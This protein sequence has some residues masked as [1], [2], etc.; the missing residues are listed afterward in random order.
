MSFRSWQKI[1][2]KDIVMKIAIN[3]IFFIFYFFANLMVKF[4]F[5]KKIK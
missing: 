5:Y 2:T 4:F 1:A 3:N